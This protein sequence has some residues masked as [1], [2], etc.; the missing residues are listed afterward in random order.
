MAYS[1]D[2]II[3]WCESEWDEWK[4]DCSGFVKAV[5]LHVDVQLHGQANQI[6]N[7][8]E[9]TSAWE[10]LGAAPRVA[11]ARAGS[12]YFVVGGLKRQPNGHVVIVVKSA[13][14]NYPV[15]YWGKLGSV[16]QKNTTINFSSNSSVRDNVQYFALR[17]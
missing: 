15:A 1:A 13:A 5:A 3:G 16:G 17:T 4:G 11:T 7:Y 12:G 8:L 6:I 14:Q 9:T 2:Q 10:N